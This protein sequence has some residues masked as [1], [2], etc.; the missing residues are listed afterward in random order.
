MLKFAALTSPVARGQ[1]DHLARLVG[2]HRERLLADDVTAGGED[3]HRLREMEV[4]RRR[5]VHGI[6]RRVVE[7]RLERRIGARDAE[8]RGPRLASFRRAAQHAADLDA[9]PAQGLDVDRADEARAD[10]RGSD[11]GDPAHALLTWCAVDSRLDILD[12]CGRRE[13]G[14]AT[15]H[16]RRA[17]IL[18]SHVKCGGSAQPA[19]DHAVAEV[20]GRRILDDELVAAVGQDLA[21]D[22]DLPS[23]V[24]GV[25]AMRG[26]RAAAPSQLDRLPGVAPSPSGRRRP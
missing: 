7:Q 24:S 3:R 22:D 20:A 14:G 5:D 15:G 21:L 4:V 1:P 25:D 18:R 2:R 17:S 13:G 16:A 11:V 8:R 23:S 12:G 6:D 9:D 19:G 26:G 10:D